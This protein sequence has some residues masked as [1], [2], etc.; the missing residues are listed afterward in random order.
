MSRNSLI[1]DT[2]VLV[3]FIVVSTHRDLV[4]KHNAPKGVGVRG[5]GHPTRS[6]NEGAQTFGPSGHGP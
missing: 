1:L 4:T 2:M 3:L 5:A 6:A